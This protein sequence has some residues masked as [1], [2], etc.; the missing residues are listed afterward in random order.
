[1]DDA[2][3]RALIELNNR[4][5]A[6][7]VAS[8]SATRATPW[9]GWQAVAELVREHGRPVRTVLDLACGNLR[10]ER[11][12]AR[13]LPESRRSIHAIDSCPA[14]VC[15][16]GGDPRE[17]S[18]AT[19]D[20]T[21][22]QADILT[23][24]LDASPLDAQAASAPRPRAHEVLPATPACDLAVCFGFMHHVPGF[25]LRSQ[26]LATLVDRTAPGGLIVLSLWQFMHDARLAAKADIADARAREHGL[27]LADAAHPFPIASDSLEPGDHFLGWQAD[28]AP[29]RYC[30]HCNASEVDA[31]V[32]FVGRR[33]REVARWAADGSSGTL[34]QYIALER[35]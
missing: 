9:N 13:E 23:A 25:E 12:L 1:M 2:L 10:F 5:Y 4:F 32:A 33:A 20:L 6:E 15:S 34:N 35:L 8:F 17:L 22:H 21:Y 28:P 29:L 30:H 7:H 26:V 19:V 16:S 3:A 24:L 27:R 31:L 14:L 18:S 11:F